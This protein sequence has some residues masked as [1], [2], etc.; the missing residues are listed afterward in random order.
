LLFEHTISG[1]YN[2][3][4][5]GEIEKL[6]S[7][8]FQV[9]FQDKYLKTMAQFTRIEVAQVMKQTGIVP[10]FYHKDIG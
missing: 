7:G 10:L 3:V 4:T 5:K 9:K 2:L 8:I 1:D 6:L